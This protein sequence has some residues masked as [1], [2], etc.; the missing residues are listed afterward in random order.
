M[1]V[2]QLRQKIRLAVLCGCFTALFSGQARAEYNMINGPAMDA[3]T[4]VAAIEEGNPVIYVSMDS[5][6]V[7]IEGK[8]GEYYQVLGDEGEGWLQI[9]VG[10]GIGYLSSENGVSI[11]K[12]EE[13]EASGGEDVTEMTANQQI[14][15]DRRQNLVDFALQFLGCPYRDAGSDPRTGVD[16]SG[17]VRYVMQHGAGVSLNRSSR[18]QAGQGAAVSAE[19]MRPGDLVFYGSGSSIN[20]VAMYIG[21]G[22][23]VH[24]STYKTGVKVSPWTYRTPVRI[25]NVLGD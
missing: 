14:A 17:F 1:S 2:S 20:H 16:C 6:E 15:D 23:V 9:Q 13:L 11:V 25:M 19:Q 21:E 10:D 5:D 22:Q 7:L 8:A 12:Q 4:Y 18:A 24:A 3:G